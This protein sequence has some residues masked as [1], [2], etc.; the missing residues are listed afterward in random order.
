MRATVAPSGKTCW[1]LIPFPLPDRTYLVSFDYMYYPA[2]PC[3]NTTS[4][5]LYPNDETMEQAI[6]AAALRHMNGPADES[7]Q[8]SLA[9]LNSMV[10]KDRITDGQVDGTNDLMRLDPDV[11]L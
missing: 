8:A 11:F 6:Q 7:Y 5:P 4:I 3:P 10:V 9:E 1:E 2:D